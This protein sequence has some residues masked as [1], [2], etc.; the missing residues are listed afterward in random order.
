MI[1]CPLPWTGIAVNPDGSVR[2]CAMSQ[3]TLG[4]LKTASI[5]SILNGEPNQHIRNSLRSGKW[6]TSCRMCEQ[7][8]SVDPEFSNRAYQLELHRDANIDYIGL[9][10]LTQLDLRLTASKG[11]LFLLLACTSPMASLGARFDPKSHI[12][13]LSRWYP[14]GR[15]SVRLTNVRGR[16]VGPVSARTPKKNRWIQR[17]FF[18]RHRHLSRH[19]DDLHW[20]PELCCFRECQWF[21]AVGN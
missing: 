9:H 13:E 8:E 19:A 15:Y 4:N 20:R 5:D 16:P 17:H 21:G 2:N 18:K 11:R 6:P 12:D 10:S 14:A 1:A 3:R 7:R